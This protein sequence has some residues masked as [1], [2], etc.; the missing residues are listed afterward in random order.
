MA[1]ALPA[2]PSPEYNGEIWKCNKKSDELVHL[3]QSS[4]GRGGGEERKMLGVVIRQLR[5]TGDSCTK[6]WCKLASVPED[7]YPKDLFNFVQAGTLC[8]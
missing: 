4:W 1:N 8:C 3:N 2:R 5:R 6:W 7:K